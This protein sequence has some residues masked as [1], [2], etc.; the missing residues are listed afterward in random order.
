MSHVRAD[1]GRRDAFDIM[2]RRTSGNDR[3]LATSV[4]ADAPAGSFASIVSMWR[5]VRSHRPL[6]AAERDLGVS[7]V[8]L[9][10]EPDMPIGIHDID[11]PDTVERAWRG[12]IQDALSKMLP[13]ANMKYNLSA[14]NCILIIHADMR[15]AL[16]SLGHAAFREIHLA[17]GAAAQDFSMAATAHG[18]FA[19]PVKM[20]R[21]A[22][23][24]SEVSLRGQAVYLLL[25]GL[26][27]SSNPTMALF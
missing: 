19:R 17:A 22:R 23:L 6:N 27:R 4:F 5:A 1:V 8:W 11:G 15:G 26:S 2:R 10:R 13:Y 24:E 3:G 18:L 25:C 9:G 20:M 12:D 21:E 7:L 16:D 14:L